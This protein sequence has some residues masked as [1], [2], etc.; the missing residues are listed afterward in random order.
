MLF[1]FSGYGN[2]TWN[3]ESFLPSTEAAADYNIDSGGM[4]FHRNE[5]YNQVQDRAELAPD[6]VR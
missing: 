2:E 5:F 1:G 4:M 3:H 6:T